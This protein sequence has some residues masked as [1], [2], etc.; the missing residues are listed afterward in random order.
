MLHYLADGL[1]DPAA[2]T[3]LSPSLMLNPTGARAHFP[4]SHTQPRLYALKLTLFYDPLW[5]SLSINHSILYPQSNCAGLDSV[6][7]GI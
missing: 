7:S 1:F 3:E 4:Y 5:K 2:R 6:T